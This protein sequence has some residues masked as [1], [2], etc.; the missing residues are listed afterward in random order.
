MKW[1]SLQI[2]L[3][4]IYLLLAFLFIGVLGMTLTISYK[5][6]LTKMREDDIKDC[7]EEIAS[8]YERGDLALIDLER[9]A[10]IPVLKMAA[11]D[12]DATILIANT[13]SRRIFYELDEN[14]LIVLTDDTFVGDELFDTVYYENRVYVRSDYYDQTL[15]KNV[16]TVA[17]PIRAENSSEKP[18]AILIITTDLATVNETFN[19]IVFTL[20]IPAIV[21]IV[22]GLLVLLLSIRGIVW[23]VRRLESATERIA[24]GK[25]DERVHFRQKDEIGHLAEQFND[26]A[27][28]LAASDLS[29]REFVSNVAHELRSPMTSING[30]VEGILDGTIPKEKHKMYLEVVSSEVKRLSAL[31]KSMLDLSRL[32][33]GR[34]KLD[35]CDFDINESIR[36]TILRFSQTIENRGIVPEVDLP[37][38]RVMVYADSDKIDEILQ[39]LTDNAIKFTENGEKLIW[40][41]ERRNGKAIVT[42]EDEG[43]GISEEDLKFIWDR[44]YTVDKARS[45][46]TRGT[47]LG[48]SIV[49][50]I[51]EQHG[52]TIDVTST[53]GKGTAFTFTLPLADERG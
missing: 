28:K 39:N 49:K 3:I 29:K 19:R 34:E 23:R 15:G 12:F 27:G 10:T 1:H 5:Y 48:L 38:E 33:S 9:G 17:V 53:L 21:I 43:T 50:S 36:R 2:K 35:K 7:A 45:G 30:F 31:V 32:E 37:E 47:G 25:F 13:T 4:A 52:E 14:R 8:L 40:R 11:R 24:K 6:N 51:I 46:K 41:V 20:W 26:M 22:A 44:F 18:W 16:S 42:V